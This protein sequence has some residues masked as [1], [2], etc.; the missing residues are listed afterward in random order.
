MWQGVAGM[1]A[2]NVL[3]VHIQHGLFTK[4]MHHLVSNCAGSSWP[5]GS[6]IVSQAS[7]QHWVYC[8]TSTDGLGTGDT[9]LCATGML[10]TRHLYNCIL[11]FV[12][13]ASLQC[14]LS[15]GLDGK[16]LVLHASTRKGVHVL[17]CVLV[18]YYTQC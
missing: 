9:I 2:S 13:L 17:F 4:C 1:L 11:F 15:V 10:L 12:S 6:F 3:C 16:E 7:S 8:I 14:K 18:M 5:V